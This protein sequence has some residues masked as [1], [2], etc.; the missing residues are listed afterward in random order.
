[1]VNF[2]KETHLKWGYGQRNSANR[3]EGWVL[4]GDAGRNGDSIALSNRK[5]SQYGQPTLDGRNPE[6]VDRWFSPL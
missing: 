5:G 3:G 4:V 6:P 1:M 2:R